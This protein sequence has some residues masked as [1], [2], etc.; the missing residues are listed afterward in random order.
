MTCTR[1]MKERQRNEVLVF[2]INDW[3]IKISL[4]IKSSEQISERRQL[5]KA[6]NLKQTQGRQS[7][8]LKHLRHSHCQRCRFRGLTVNRFMQCYC[9]CQTLRMCL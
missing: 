6:A 1:L 5:R 4:L 9:S 7:H 8:T 2:I 3:V